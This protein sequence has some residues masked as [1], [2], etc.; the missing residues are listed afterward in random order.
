MLKTCFFWKKG[1]NVAFPT[2]NPSDTPFP[3]VN[4]SEISSCIKKCTEGAENGEFQKIKIY[5]KRQIMQ[6][7]PLPGSLP[8]TRGGGVGKA[9]LAPRASS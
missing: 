5:K 9:S 7:P 2:I 6:F 4:D 8:P 1:K 3:P